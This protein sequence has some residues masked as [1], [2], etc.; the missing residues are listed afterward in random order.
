MRPGALELLPNIEVADLP[1]DRRQLT[2]QVAYLFDAPTGDWLQRRRVESL[3]RFQ[4]EA[5]VM[6]GASNRIVHEK[7][8][9]KRGTVVC[10]DGTNREHLIAAPGQQHG[11]TLRVPE[12]HRPVR[13]RREFNSLGEIGS[14][15]FRLFFAHS[16]LSRIS[17]A[18]MTDFA[19]ARAPQF[20]CP[21]LERVRQAARLFWPQ[22]AEMAI[23]NRI[24]SAS[25]VTRSLRA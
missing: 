19:I 16:I 7:S 5:R 12:Q 2:R 23:Q 1:L 13:N 3:A 25:L 9:F 11:L 10:A 18:L 24:W 6:P 14:V 15:E 8:R 17:F 20:P 21:W 22:R 4:T